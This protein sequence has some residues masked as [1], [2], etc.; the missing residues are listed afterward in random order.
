MRLLIVL[1]WILGTLLSAEPLVLIANKRFPLQSLDEH[2]IKQIFL[3]RTHY[4]GNTELFPVNLT[5][6]DAYRK[7][8][9]QQVLKMSASK[10]RKH[11][12]KRHY[13][14]IRP[15]LVRESIQNSI[16]FVRKIDGAIAYIPQSDVPDD[17]MILYKV[18]R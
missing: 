13:E 6:Q 15:P 9:E 4:I 14:G 11:W 16:S 8:F 3:K 7:A 10:L 17:L 5:A 12:T 1:V 18:E 2:Q